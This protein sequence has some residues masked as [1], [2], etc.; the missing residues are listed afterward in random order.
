MAAQRV[1]RTFFRE[2]GNTRGKR[3]L[4]A[5]ASLRRTAAGGRDPDARIGIAGTYACRKQSAVPRAGGGDAVP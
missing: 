2:A 1:A 3:R 4:D 5:C